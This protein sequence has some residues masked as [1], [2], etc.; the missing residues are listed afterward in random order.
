MSIRFLPAVLLPS[1]D[2][3]VSTLAAACRWVVKVSEGFQT[4]H[5]SHYSYHASLH[6]YVKYL[7]LMMDLGGMD[8][9]FKITK[10]VRLKAASVSDCKANLSWLTQQEFNSCYPNVL[11]LDRW[12][13]LIPKNITQSFLLLLEN[14]KVASI[15]QVPAVGQHIT[16]PK[17]ALNQLLV[18]NKQTTD[19]F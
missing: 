11:H 14:L 19:V 17:S 5:T 9:F 18:Q 7:A 10:S 15:I 13:K 1:G 2:K 12:Q 6:S 8:A 16:Q 4:T 3:V